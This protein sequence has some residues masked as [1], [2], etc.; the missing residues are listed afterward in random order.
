MGALKCVTLANYFRRNCLVVQVKRGASKVLDVN[1]SSKVM[2]YSPS[3]TILKS[4][5][6]SNVETHFLNARELLGPV[7]RGKLGQVTQVGSSLCE[8]LCHG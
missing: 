5:G 2:H 3:C 8:V 6:A 4:G 7:A 1:F